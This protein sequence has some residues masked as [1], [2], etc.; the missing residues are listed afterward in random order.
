MA[1]QI[2]CPSKLAGLC[3]SNTFL[4]GVYKPTTNHLYDEAAGTKPVQSQSQKP[5]RC[6]FIVREGWLVGCIGLSTTDHPLNQRSPPLARPFPLAKPDLAFFDHVARFDVYTLPA[7][8]CQSVLDQ[9][10]SQCRFLTGEPRCGRVKSLLISYVQK[11][12][13]AL[14]NDLEPLWNQEMT[15]STTNTSHLRSSLKTTPC[16]PLSHLATRQAL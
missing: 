11:L 10:F 14:L 2:N 1:L 8:Y 3:G 16:R 4:P 5:T 7:K 12:Y 15:N 13:L 6:Y 9:H